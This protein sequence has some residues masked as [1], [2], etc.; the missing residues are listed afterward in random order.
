MKKTNKM[1]LTA[2]VG[3]ASMM[4]ALPLSTSAIIT[5]E[6]LGPERTLCGQE[7]YENVTLSEEGCG[8][9]LDGLEI[10]GKLSIDKDIT[11]F[12]RKEVKLYGGSDL[13]CHMVL[14]EGSKLE[15][16]GSEDVDLSQLE[17]L[18]IRKGAKLV[19]QDYWSKPCGLI[20]GN[21]DTCFGC[22]EVEI[23]GNVVEYDY[24]LP[25]R[26]TYYFDRDPDPCV[27]NF[28]GGEGVVEV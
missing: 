21:P 16:N 5:D 9:T 10:Y 22:G 28:V 23:H 17:S 4:V 15:F 3:V 1:L 13:K 11:I 8:Y 2:I 6:D 7:V 12:V 24:N 14:E 19:I 27:L 18:E 20:F 26:V 25:W